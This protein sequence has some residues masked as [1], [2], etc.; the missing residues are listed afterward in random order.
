MKQNNHPFIR[1]MLFIAILFMGPL[2]VAALAPG[3]L[4]DAQ[5]PRTNVPYIYATEGVGKYT[6]STNS[7]IGSEVYCRIN[8]GEWFHYKKPLVFTEYGTYLFEAYAVSYDDVA[9]N[10]VS[11]TVVVDEH[12][13]ENLVDSD[14]E[15]PTIFYYD[16][17]KYKINGSTVSLTEQNDAMVSGDLIIPPSIT[18]NGVTYP[19][20]EIERY[21]LYNTN[22]ITS[23]HIP[24][25]VTT[26]GYNSLS[27]S[28]AVSSITVDPDNPNYCDIDGVLFSKDKTLLVFY[29]NMH[30]SHYTI[31]EGVTVIDYS[32]FEEAFDLVSVTFPSSLRNLRTSAFACCRSLASVTMPANLTTMGY[33]VF[34]GCRGLKSI[35]FTPN[36]TKIAESTFE[37]CYSLENVV[38]PSTIKTIGYGAFRECYHLSNVTLSE[39]VKTIEDNAFSM[40]RHLP[41]ITIPSSVSSI[42]AGAFFNCVNLT[43]INIDPANNYYCDV[44]G[45]LYNKNKTTLVIY[46]IGNPRKSYTVLPTTQTIGEKSFQYCK[47]LKSIMIPDA[48]TSIGSKAIGYC[49]SITDITCLATVPPTAASDAFYNYSSV[50]TTLRVPFG[51]IGAYQSTSPWSDFNPIVGAA[52][53]GDVNGN[54]TVEMDDL[55]SFINMLL[56]G[57]APGYADLNGDGAVNMDDLTSLINVLLGVTPQPAEPQTGD[58]ETIT[59]N[60][61]SFNMVY[62]ASGTFEMGAPPEAYYNVDYCRP[63]HQ[64]TLSPYYIGQTEVTQELWTAVMGSNPSYYVESNQQPVHLIS[65]YDC[66]TFVSRLSQLTGKNFRLPTEAEWEYAA[67]GADL[68]QGYEYAGGTKEEL[69]ALCWNSSNTALDNYTW[70]AHPV[71]MKRPNEIGLYDMSGNVEEWLSDYN[72]PYT[73][74]AQVNPQG[75]ET[76]TTRIA[77]GGCYSHNWWDLRVFQ[78]HASNPSDKLSFYGMRLAM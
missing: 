40:C 41:S 7:V 25:T 69:N 54:G 5:Q 15:D 67:R 29:P 55:S 16:G 28:A 1:A 66:Q 34:H 61:V 24:S 48:V 49:D 57:D 37:G 50:V 76:G 43:N 3:L 36:Y 20:T 73:E 11:Q 32:A 38:I 26:V 62:V 30:G 17:F 56:S 74:E 9:S 53:G 14:T 19:V 52:V 31:P 75:P 33:G 71:A 42:Q 6:V 65:W 18:H 35:T 23:I 47:K 64:V 58:V 45:V 44:D 8:S 63:V 27:W 39:G 77:R 21:A 78:R 12:T 4:T 72:G 59:V 51:S 46:P 68:S 10:I 70:G 13:G 2:G 60:G 22:N